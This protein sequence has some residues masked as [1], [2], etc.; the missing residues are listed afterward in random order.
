MWSEST[1]VRFPVGMNG[2]RICFVQVLDVGMVLRW[3]Y[4][5]PIVYEAHVASVISIMFEVHKL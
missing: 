1:Q 4:D 3:D 2:C 5:V